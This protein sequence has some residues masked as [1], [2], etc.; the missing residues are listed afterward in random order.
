M[1]KSNPGSYA[2]TISTAHRRTVLVE[3]LSEAACRLAGIS[4]NPR[5]NSQFRSNSAES[6]L[7]E[8][9]L[10]SQTRLHVSDDNL[11]DNKEMQI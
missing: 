5:T 7:T 9:D 3:I 1:S 8:L 2:E 6:S 11:L 4:V 10:S